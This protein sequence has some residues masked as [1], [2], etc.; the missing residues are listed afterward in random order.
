MI[1]A[2]ISLEINFFLLNCWSH[3]FSLSG[4]LIVIKESFFFRL[5]DWH[6]TPTLAIFLLYHGDFF[7][8][9]NVTNNKYFFTCFTD[10]I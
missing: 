3:L 2:D 1:I 8:R 10:F 5:I 6:L 4:L 9:S 7:S